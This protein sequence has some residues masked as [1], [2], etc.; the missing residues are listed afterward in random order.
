[1][2]DKTTRTIHNLTC[3][4]LL[5]VAGVAGAAVT[6]SLQGVPTSVAPGQSVTVGIQYVRPA[7]EPEK[8]L[9]FIVELRQAGSGAVLARQVQ[10]NANAGHTPAA[11]TVPVT[12]SVPANASGS[13]YFT[14]HAVPW[15]LNRA[16]V[17]HYKSYPTNGTFTYLWSG[18]GY[19]VT[20]NVYY[21]Q[22][23]I[24]PKPS[25]NT[26]YCSGLAFETA[27]LPFN[28]YNIQYGHARIGNITA[29]QMET[30]RRIWY[31]VTDAEKLAARAIPEYGIGLEITDLEEAQEGDFVQFWRHNG[32]GHNPVFVNWVRNSSNQITGV[33]YWGSQLSSNGIG[34]AT[35]S[36]GTTSGINRNRFYLARIRKPRDQADLDWALGTASTL[37]TPTFIGVSSVDDWMRY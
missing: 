17:A 20:Q 36:F 24:C 8:R 25:G 26:T 7:S 15:S 19:G 6:V 21:L 31:G 5:C 4:A 9:I 35:E 13:S 18:G 33:R 2:R 30:F 10:D 29:S 12:L 34:Y 28:A 11:G 1:M 22:T 3:A 16:I 37:S 27:I 23:L 32:S 14:A